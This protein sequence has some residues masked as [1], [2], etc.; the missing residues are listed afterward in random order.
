M[1]FFVSISCLTTSHM[2]SIG[3]HTCRTQGSVERKLQSELG[4]AVIERKWC[5]YLSVCLVLFISHSLTAP[6]HPEGRG[7]L[8][9]VLSLVFQSISKAKDRT[10]RTTVL[11]PIAV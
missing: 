7:N 5:E 10:P 4:S 8:F 1:N 11:P 9:G 3:S 2:R 6:F